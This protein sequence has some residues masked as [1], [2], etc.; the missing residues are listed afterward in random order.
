V[1]QS[2][3]HNEQVGAQEEGTG[4]WIL[5]TQL[6]I[7]WENGNKR[8]LVIYGTGMSF[9]K[10]GDASFADILK[11]DV[12]KQSSGREFL[13]NLRKN[14]ADRSSASIANHLEAVCRSRDGSAQRDLVVKFYFSFENFAHPKDLESLLKSIIQQLSFAPEIFSELR[15]LY[16]EHTR[17]YPPSSPSTAEMQRVL[18]SGLKARCSNVKTPRNVFLVIDALDE[19]PKGSRREEVINFLKQLE[20]FKIPFLHVLVTYRPEPDISK[21]IS[22]PQSSWVGLEVNKEATRAD[23][24]RYVNNVLNTFFGDDLIDD[25]KERVRERLTK[26]QDGM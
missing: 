7:D 1:D 18:I 24:G 26:D 21:R 14:Y 8:Y 15:D 17:T 2:K 4:G 12:G 9:N 10:F 3:F 13:L 5:E 19:I 6:Y 11:L 16:E 25:T 22:G 20:D 23:I